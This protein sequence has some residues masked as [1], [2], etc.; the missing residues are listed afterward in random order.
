MM[1]RI[2]ANARGYG[3]EIYLSGECPTSV[4]F[5]CAPIQLLIEKSL[6]QVPGVIFFFS[7]KFFQASLISTQDEGHSCDVVFPYGW[8]GGAL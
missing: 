2:R 6:C 3:C 5:V 4:L 8:G 1:I 7:S